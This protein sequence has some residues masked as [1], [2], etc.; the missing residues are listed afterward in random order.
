MERSQK[1]KKPGS[2][3]KSMARLEGVER[4]PTKKKM[5]YEMPYLKM[6]VKKERKMTTAPPK[7]TVVEE[8]TEAS[9]EQGSFGGSRFGR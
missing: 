9:K 3:Q 5:N 1:R 7:R 8:G 2:W 6:K 4:V